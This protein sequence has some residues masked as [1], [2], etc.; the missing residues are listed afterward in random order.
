MNAKS[1]ERARHRTIV[2]EASEYGE[3]YAYSGDKFARFW[4]LLLGGFKFGGPWN[5]ALAYVD[6]TCER[7]AEDAED[8]ICDASVGEVVPGEV[9]S[10]R[11]SKYYESE[12]WCC[13]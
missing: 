2:F 13:F 5:D 7:T 10:R 8:K 9:F 1:F 4:L 11:F 6:W 12:D 3:I